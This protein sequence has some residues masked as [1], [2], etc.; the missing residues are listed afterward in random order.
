MILFFFPVKEENR[1]RGRLEKYYV[2]KDYHF[3]SLF[4]RVIY[5]CKIQSCVRVAARVLLHGDPQNNLGDAGSW[6]TQGEGVGDDGFNDS[7]KERFLVFY[8]PS[9]NPNFGLNLLLAAQLY[10]SK[11]RTGPEIS[12]R[13]VALVLP[14]LQ[15]CDHLYSINFR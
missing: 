4:M 6:Q 8:P 11:L 5:E 1:W 2:M 12:I 13:F 3:L 7:H 15:S 14:S 10:Y 9:F